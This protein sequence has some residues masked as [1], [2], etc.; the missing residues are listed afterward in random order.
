MYT[1]SHL[2]KQH[3]EQTPDQVSVILLRSGQ[4]DRPVTYREIIYGAAGYAE[5]YQRNGIQAGDV[6]VR[7]GR[8]VGPQPSLERAGAR[9]RNARDHLAVSP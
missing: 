4:S 7:K 5:T 8:P 3:Y 1:F 9:R 2:L 6:V